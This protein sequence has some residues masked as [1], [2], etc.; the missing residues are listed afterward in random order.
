VMALL[1]KGCTFFLQLISIS[2]HPI[3]VTPAQRRETLWEPPGFFPAERQCHHGD[4]HR[5][6]CF[7]YSVTRARVSCRFS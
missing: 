5:W 6:K 7:V 2:L 3:G 4:S 1:E